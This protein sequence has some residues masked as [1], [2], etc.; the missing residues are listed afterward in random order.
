MP[1]VINEVIVRAVI[2]GDEGKGAGN[3]SEASSPENIAAVTK[4]E[5]PEIID[6]VFNDKKER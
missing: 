4:N 6:E 5:L 3:A 2:S 1:V